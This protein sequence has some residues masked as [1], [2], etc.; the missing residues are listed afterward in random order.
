MTTL[1]HISD[2]HFGR[3]NFRIIAPLLACLRLIQPELVIIS[4]D[5]TQR[6]R[7]KEFAA[8]QNFL[9]R[10]EWPYLIIPGNHDISAFNLIERFCYPWRKWYRHIGDEL[11][12]AMFMND[13]VIIGVNTTR[14]LAS[15]FD[16]SRGRIS[17]SQAKNLKHSLSGDKSEGLRVVVAHHPFW[18]PEPYQ[19]R[20][21]V[22]G[23][24]FAIQQMSK[25]RV[26]LI[27]SGHVHYAY[28]Q[29][30]NGIIISHAGTAISD[31]LVSQSPNSFKV[32]RGSSIRLEI[33]TLVWNGKN[34]FSYA[35]EL[36][37]NTENGWSRH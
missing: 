2:L 35:H 29:I 13:N 15:L 28:T 26:D 9:A 33:D 20:H 23:R 11:E 30:L 12:P 24:D 31:R 37:V 21:I 3:E 19:H 32:V 14:R 6:A 27:F 18:L 5:I 16:W 7:N 22:G 17:T 4:G 34:F 10:L 8:A 36:F 1:A 25:V